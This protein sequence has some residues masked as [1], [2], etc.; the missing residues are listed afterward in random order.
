MESRED[1]INLILLLLECVFVEVDVTWLDFEVL[2][3]ANGRVGH[4]KRA[5]IEQSLNLRVVLERGHRVID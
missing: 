1:S 2:I 4:C 3:L 5:Q